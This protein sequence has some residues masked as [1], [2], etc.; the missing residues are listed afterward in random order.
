MK[1]QTWI[2]LIKAAFKKKLKK[3]FMITLFKKKW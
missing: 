3:G 2:E 1:K